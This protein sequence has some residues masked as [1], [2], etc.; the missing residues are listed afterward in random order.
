MSRALT[1]GLQVCART[2]VRKLRELPLSGQVM[3]E[4]GQEVDAHQ[5]V[6]C[7]LVPGELHVL[8][9]P[10]RLGLDPDEVLEDLRIQEG[11]QVENGAVL[12][13]HQSFFG[14]LK[15]RFVSPVSGQVE[16]INV[17]SG[18]VGLREV[19]RPLSLLAHVSGRVV[20]IE[21]GKSVTIETE[22]AL[23]QGIF[24]IG[25][26]Q[27]GTLRLLAVPAGRE[28]QEID[29][30][31]QIK[32]SILVGGTR[33]SLQAL[34]A[35]ARQ[36]AA[37]WVVGSIDDRALAG[38]LG[39]D[40]GIALTGDEDLSMTVIITEGFGRMPIAGRI[41]EVLARFD[42]S[43]ASINGATQVRA[44][45]L[46][47]EIIVSGLETKL[48][49]GPSSAILSREQEL[50]VGSFVR[51]IRVPYFGQRAKVLSL[52]V[53]LQTLETGAR[54]RVL[55]AELEGGRRV[56]VPRTNVELV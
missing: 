32:G 33:P 44:G 7:A 2:R 18:H 30:P 5:V 56:F 35:A 15:S 52:P 45:A 50:E 10:E 13:E 19:A 23:V 39:Y 20:S 24:G 38:Y 27:R 17:R 49:E 11:Q 1:P 55:E 14:L 31:E 16:F 51:I 46:R 6:A 26:E 29:L 36:G 41:L 8:R 25:G 40:L 48:E 43:P 21:A 54:A 42:G 4:L 34:Q 22:C 3:V 28:V 37:G 9:I 12:C 53:E 47:P